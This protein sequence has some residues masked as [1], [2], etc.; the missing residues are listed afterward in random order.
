MTTWA[1]EFQRPKV[2]D[3]PPPLLVNDSKGNPV[4]LA[5]YRG[6]VVIVTFWASWCGPCRKELPVLAHFQR[7]IG[8]DALEVIAINFQESKSDFNA[9][10]RRNRGKIDLTYVFDGKGSLSD[11]YQVNAVP[12]MFI[13][14]RQGQVA[15]V[16]VGYSES[17]LPTIIDEIIA[18]LPPEVQARPA[19]G[20]AGSPAG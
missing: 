1:G 7:V 12:N 6:K 13:I 3:T 9:I 19:G 5:Q 15:H 20:T 14:D 17:A 16:H 18:L 11:Q 8:R 4:D 10:V 2:G